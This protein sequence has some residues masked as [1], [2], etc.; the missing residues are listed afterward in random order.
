MRIVIDCFKQVKGVGKSIG[1]YNVAV[2]LVNNLVLEKRKT[3]NHTIKTSE[4]I[5]FGNKF[6]REDF[7]IEGVQFVEIDNYN[8]LNKMH[9][10]WWELFGASKQCRKY[11]ADKILYPRGYCTLTHP[12]EDIVLIHD[13]IPFYYAENFPGVFN[14]YENW[15]I[16]SRL[17]Q[18]ART[19][20][21][22]ITISEASKADIIKYSGVS[23]KKI[24]VINNACNVVNYIPTNDTN[25][26]PYISAITSRL[27]HKNAKGVL[28]SYEEYR[29]ISNTPLDLHVIGIDESFQTDIDEET[30][31][32]VIFHKYIK[33]NK[34]MYKLISH[35]EMFLF[36]SLVEG[37]GLPPIEAMQL[38][39]PVI[40]SDVSSLPEVVGDAA[41]LVDPMDYKQVAAELVNLQQ[42]K[43][44]RDELV[45]KGIENVRRFSWSGRA[46]LYWKTILS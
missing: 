23:E 7:K 16:M 28:K 4:I 3:D 32:H 6:N 15:Y 21:K 8:P 35:S 33:D 44:L 27:P 2:S 45:K 13:M 46:K 29:K 43:D 25:N 31:K 30:K 22:I 5:V 20:K 39:V 14:K 41:I 37:F 36:L 42:N 34:D 11:K 26:I 10:I 12:V 1:I 19:A 40:C 38:D 9:C 24:T 18:S 17:K